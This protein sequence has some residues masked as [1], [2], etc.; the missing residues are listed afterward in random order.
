MVNLRAFVLKEAP[1]FWRSDA[2]EASVRPLGCSLS[3]HD[4]HARTP[5]QWGHSDDVCVQSVLSFVV[6]L[7]TELIKRKI[8]L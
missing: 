3:H 7:T 4:T 5:S 2:F 8:K 6:Q 1:D